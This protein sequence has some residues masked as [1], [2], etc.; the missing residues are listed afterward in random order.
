MADMDTVKFLMDLKRYKDVLPKQTMKTLKGQALSGDLEG[1]KKG[2]GTVL[3][4][5]AGRCERAQ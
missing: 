5:R 4:R 2:L 3:R 1:A